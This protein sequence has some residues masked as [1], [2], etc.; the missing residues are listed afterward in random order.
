MDS[1]QASVE[2]ASR[3][4]LPGFD[5]VAARIRR[6]EL[7]MGEPTRS[8]F[9][10]RR[11]LYAD[12]AASGRA[13]SFIES[14]V[15]RLL[16][17]YANV[18]SASSTTG[19]V[20]SEVREAARRAVARGVNA[21]PDDVL[22]FV[23]SGATAALEKLV[24][25]LGLRI[26]E[27][28][29]RAHQLSRAIP[30]DR[31]PVVLVGPY[32]H[33][34]NILPWLES[35]AEV[36]EVELD[37]QGGI[38]LED[39]QRKAHAYR[40]RPLRIGAISAASNVTGVITDVGAVCRLLHRHG[41]LAC[42]DFTAAAPSMPVDMHPPDPAERID[43]LSLS[44][45]KL[46]GGPGASGILVAHTGLFRSRTPVRPGGGTVDFVGPAVEEPEGG[47][48]H[49]RCIR[50]SYTAKL[51]D[52]EEGGTPNILGDVRAGLAF[53]LRALL[54]PERTLAHELRLSQQILSRLERLPRLR[55]LGP[56]TCARLPIVAFNVEGLHHGLVAVLL[57]QLFGIQCRD[58]CS[59]A[60]PYGHRLLG[61]PPDRSARFRELVE[62]GVL[63]VRP[64]WVRLSVPCYASAADLDYLA[65]A[66]EL[67]AEHGEVF[68]P[69]Y[70]FSWLDGRWRAVRGPPPASPRLELD[71]A[72]IWSG[73]L[74]P[75]SLERERREQDPEPARRRFL[76]EAR[77]WVAELG[78]RW[79]KEPPAWNR[80]TGRASIDELVWF[81]YVETEGL[82]TS[83][84]IVRTEQVL[85]GPVGPSPRRRS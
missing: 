20:T 70:R 75:S 46:A 65:S 47:E 41:A 77:A 26:P 5:Q 62:E 9:G 72:A 76:E 33:H 7:G 34:S 10:D 29:E 73:M 60:G 63:G 67:I 2:G 57:D 38:D 30:R 59:C 51:T 61:I 69:L 36:V 78:S 15:R 37:R 43:A 45:H 52:R 81:R 66:V 85:P 84:H 25:L 13:L 27:P 68:V 16:P 64:G 71:P 53:G 31:R 58:G 83:D 44:A 74:G 23:G 11:I 24:G 17:F 32:E 39:L 80:P 22:L 12:H 82:E 21:G 8:P 48:G 40:E 55:L 14:S 50:V 56:R 3:G 28:L 18:H 42:I 1:R 35:I 6:A 4:E 54:G 49:S 19:R 79:R